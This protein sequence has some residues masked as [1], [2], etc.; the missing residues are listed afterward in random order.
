MEQLRK[1]R[2]EGTR[3]LGRLLLPD[4]VVEPAEHKTDAVVVAFS[5]PK[6]AFA[7]TVLREIMKVESE[8]ASADSASVDY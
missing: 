4:I 1:A 5:L 3:R 6:G 2:I 8:E 7:T